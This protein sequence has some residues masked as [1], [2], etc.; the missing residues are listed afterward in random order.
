MRTMTESVCKEVRPHDLLLL[1][2]EEAFVSCTPSGA[3]VKTALA[4]SRTVV[5]RRDVVP[6]GMIPVGVRG[7]TRSER[8]AGVV[9][10]HSVLQVISPEYLVASRAWRR[11]ARHSQIPVFAYLDYVFEAWKSYGLPWGPTGS[12]GFELAT[13][14]PAARPESDLDLRIVARERLSRE[15]AQ[16]LLAAVLSEKI[17]IDVQI[18]TP[19]GAI[20]LVEY[21][22]GSATMLLRTKI[23]PFLI[24]DPWSMETQS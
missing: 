15:V 2:S 18:E 23:G 12:V 4:M 5:V 11:M 20:S 8:C 21:V 24:K 7:A 14:I 13:G 22:R 3:W 19:R 17:R 1:D 16:S 10:T 9:P 6:E